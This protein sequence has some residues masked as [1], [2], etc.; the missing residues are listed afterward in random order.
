MCHI[1]AKVGPVHGWVVFFLSQRGS[2][3]P[4]RCRLLE[5]DRRSRPCLGGSWAIQMRTAGCVRRTWNLFL[6]VS[7]RF[8]PKRTR[9]LPPCH[10]PLQRRNSPGPHL[11]FLGSSFSPVPFVPFH[12]FLS[13]GKDPRNLPINRRG[14]RR[15]WWCGSVRQTSRHRRNARHVRIITRHVGTLRPCHHGLLAGRTP[16]RARE[17]GFGS[18]STRNWTCKS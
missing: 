15:R 6:H 2:K 12:V 13:I 18:K 11:G 17:E 10:L 4:F 16:V 14:G 3:S 8:H 7:K 5:V 1:V 9:A